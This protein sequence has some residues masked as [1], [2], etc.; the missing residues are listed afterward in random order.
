MWREM[1]N[2]LYVQVEKDGCLFEDG[3]SG[4]EVLLGVMTYRVALK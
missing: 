1:T 3:R 2:Q 4:C